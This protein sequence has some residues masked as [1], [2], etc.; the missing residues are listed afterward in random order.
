MS[1]KIYSF[2]KNNAGAIS[3]PKMNTLSL[4]GKTC[5]IPP[6]ET[7][8]GSFHAFVISPLEEFKNRTEAN[9]PKF[10]FCVHKNVS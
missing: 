8:V 6:T 9:V 5:V 1:Q 7:L 4:K 2:N 10:G 3:V